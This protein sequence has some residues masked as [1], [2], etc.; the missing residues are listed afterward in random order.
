M[1]R[2]KIKME[3]E[4][5]FERCLLCSSQFTSTQRRL[6]KCHWFQFISFKYLLNKV[7]FCLFSWSFDDMYL[8]KNF[9]VNIFKSWLCC[10][11]FVNKVEEFWLLFNS[12]KICKKNLISHFHFFYKN[13]VKSAQPRLFLTFC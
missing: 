11:Y 1:R 2:N 9:F 6:W 5:I 3:S 4:K 8:R 10:I 7:I 13:E 12:F